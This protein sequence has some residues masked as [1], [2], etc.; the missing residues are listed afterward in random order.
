MSRDIDTMIGGLAT[1]TDRQAADLLPDDA[2]DALAAASPPPPSCP[3][4]VGGG[5][6]RSF[7]SASRWRRRAWP[8]RP[9]P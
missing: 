7:S 4:G 3:S 6:R 1:V 8:A 9:W 5:A 2:A